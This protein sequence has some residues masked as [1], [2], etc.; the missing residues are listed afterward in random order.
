MTDRP[1]A[2]ALS[3]RKIATT[4]LLD[5]PREEHLTELPNARLVVTTL[6]TH[7]SRYRHPR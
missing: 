5:A 6:P 4:R 1:N 2:D 3:A 7:G